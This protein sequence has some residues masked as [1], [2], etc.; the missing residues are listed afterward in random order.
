MV[1]RNFR[2]LLRDAALYATSLTLGNGCLSTSEAKENRINDDQTRIE[3]PSKLEDFVHNNI[4]RWIETYH[5]PHI[6]GMC[7]S[8]QKTSDEMMPCAELMADMLRNAGVQNVKILREG[9]SYPSVYGEI[10]SPNKNVPTLLIGGHYDTQPAV[11]AL[12]TITKPFEPKIIIKD[13]K[14]E[15]CGRGSSDD[16]QALTHLDA[17]EAYVKTGTPLPINIKFLLEGGEEKGSEEMD[18]LIEKYKDLLKTD[19]VLITDSGNIRPSVPAITYR[20]RGLVAMY[21][22]VKTAE[23]DP[24]SGDGGSVLCNA[25]TAL[26]WILSGLIEPKTQQCLLP[27]FYDD[28]QKPSEAETEHIKSLEYDLNG[29]MDTYKIKHIIPKNVE[30]VKSA[31]WTQPTSEIHAIYRKKDKE[32]KVVP[33]EDGNKT[34]SE[35]EAYFTMRLVPNQDPNKIAEIATREIYQRAKQTCL[36]PDQIRINVISRDYPAS[37]DTENVYVKARSRA[38]SMIFGIQP[39]IVP[40]GGT[41]PIVGFYQG[42]LK[43]PV[44][45]DS[46]DTMDDKAH[47][48]DECFSI[49]KSLVPMVLTNIVTYQLLL[50]TTK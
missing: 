39:D 19:V 29:F 15:L 42:I 41:E 7:I 45:Y 43:A 4:D 11:E 24:H 37:A 28:V 35:A 25:N 3:V 46:A 5:K 31:M 38:L 22:N 6:T 13:G 36:A 1:G 40:V 17:I 18:K 27:R 30:E 21:I 9:E 49:E 32:K 16:G 44:V 20:S 26:T 10:K 47:G 2:K 12:W 33:N 8:K 14:R 34:T 50:N 48:N 23:N